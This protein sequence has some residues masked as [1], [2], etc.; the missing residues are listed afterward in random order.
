MRI[1]EI[2]SAEE[3]L[4]LWKLISDNIWTAISQQ[5][6]AERRQRAEKAAQRKLKPKIGGKRGGRKSLPPPPHITP[7][8]PPK[9]QPPPQAKTEVGKQAAQ[10]MGGGMKQPQAN[11]VTPQQTNALPT[12]QIGGGMKQQQANT[13]KPQQPNALPT[14]QKAV[15]MAQQQPNVTNAQAA[16]LQQ[17]HAIQQPLTPQ[18]M[19]LQRQNVGVLAKNSAVIK[20]M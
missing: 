15:G 17:P 16:H 19:R 20:R 9:K 10:Q 7:P 14:Q 6:E 11:A 1:N 8:P 3:Q 2:A 4:A 5:A 13:A 12:Q 18:Q